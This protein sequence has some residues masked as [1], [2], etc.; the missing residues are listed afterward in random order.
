QTNTAT[1]ERE[2]VHHGIT[3][4]P[5]LRENKWRSD[6]IQHPHHTHTR[7]AQSFS[8]TYTHTHTHTHTPPSTHYL[9]Y[10]FN[11]CRKGFLYVSTQTASNNRTARSEEHTS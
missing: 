2:Q 6:M 5:H 3:S 9:T 8:L 4:Q 7:A 1:P 10:P 11:K